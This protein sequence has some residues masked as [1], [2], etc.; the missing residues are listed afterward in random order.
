VVVKVVPVV[1]VEAEV[2]VKLAAVVEVGVVK[3]V[4]V[5]VLEVEVLV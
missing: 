1:L 5:L 2:P 3:A 4:L